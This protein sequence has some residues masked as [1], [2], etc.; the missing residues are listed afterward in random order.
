MRNLILMMGL[1]SVTSA[2]ETPQQTAAA[3]AATGAVIGASVS[4]NDLRGALIGGA[5]GL[6]V[7]TLIGQASTPGDCIYRDAYGRQIIAPCG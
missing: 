4:D 6:A 5:A 3:S 1:I 7:G 2:C